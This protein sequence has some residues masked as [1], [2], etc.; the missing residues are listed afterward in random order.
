M[1][2]V[3]ALGHLLMDI[4]L[5]LSDR[6]EGGE[7]ALVAELR[8]GGGG[9]AS[10]FAVAARRLGARSAIVTSV[11][12]DNFGRILLEELLREGVDIS[13]VKIVIGQQTGTS[14]L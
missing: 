3:V 12:F 10:N 8:Y 7:A 9:S 14:F 6:P 5:Y 11:G 13:R 4:Q 2:S 1:P